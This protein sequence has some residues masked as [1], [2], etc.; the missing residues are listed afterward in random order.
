MWLEFFSL[1]RGTNIILKRHIPVSDP[2]H[3]KRRQGVGG[4]LFWRLSF[5]LGFS[6][7]EGG[8]GGGLGPLP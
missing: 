2:H 4:C 1:I 5:L 6:V 3:E 7:N 8:W